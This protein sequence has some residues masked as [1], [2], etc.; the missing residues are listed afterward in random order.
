MQDSVIADVLMA[1][2]RIHDKLNR[3]SSERNYHNA[4]EI[5]L[6]YHG[7]DFFS[8]PRYANTYRGVEIG[9]VN[10]DLIVLSKNDEMVVELKQSKNPEKVEEQIRYYMEVSD[11]DTGVVICFNQSLEY[12]LFLR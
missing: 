2:Q 11:V 7:I 5:E 4:L 8:E 12:E 9:Y 6:S 3:S 10:P 1:A